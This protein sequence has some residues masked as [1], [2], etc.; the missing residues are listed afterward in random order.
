MGWYTVD[1]V[2]KYRIL[3]NVSIGELRKNKTIVFKFENPTLSS[4]PNNKFKALWVF[5]DVRS[6]NRSSEYGY[7]DMVYINLYE[8]RPL[9]KNGRYT[10][11]VKLWFSVAPELTDDSTIDIIVIKGDDIR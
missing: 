6:Y 8:C 7:Y 11:E 3:K 10:G 2:L 9:Y 4:E 5:S 1:S